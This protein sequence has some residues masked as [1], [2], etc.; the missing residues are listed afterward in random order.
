MFGV[1]CIVQIVVAQQDHPWKDSA[2]RIPALDPRLQKT[3][4]KLPAV[5]RVPAIPAFATIIATILD[6]GGYDVL[7]WLSTSDV[8]QVC[9]SSERLCMSRPSRQSVI[10][11]F[12]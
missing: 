10:V 2:V 3:V 9:S 7:D 1:M 4:G 5:L 11:L 12:V 8:Q 6:D